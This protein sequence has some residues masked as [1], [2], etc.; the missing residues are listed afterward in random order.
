MPVCWVTDRL[1]VS[2]IFALAPGDFFVVNVAVSMLDVP[3][4]ETADPKI[5]QQ[6]VAVG[7]AALKDG[8][9]VVTLCA[10][11]ASRS[12]VVAALILTAAEG[13]PFADALERVRRAVP[14]A[15]PHPGFLQACGVVE[16]GEVLPVP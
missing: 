11:G 2:S 9:R 1:G 10:M 7:V 13:M 12:V 15:A 5:I 6:R 14:Q 8:A 4:D 3:D 16:R